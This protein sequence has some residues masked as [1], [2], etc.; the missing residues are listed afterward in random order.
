MTQ[1]ESSDRPDP[2]LMRQNYDAVLGIAR[3]GGF[4]R[5]ESGWTAELGLAHLLT[6][7]ETFVSVGDGGA[8]GE[9]PAAGNPER[10]AAEPPATRV[11][12]PGRLDGVSGRPQ[13][14]PA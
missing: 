11:V 2:A 1:A 6:V 10:L 14:P 9:H 3:R 8:R 13:A 7:T 5:P 12:E 4:R